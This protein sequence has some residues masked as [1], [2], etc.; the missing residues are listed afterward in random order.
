LLRPGRGPELREFGRHRAAEVA[1][2]DRHAVA[3]HHE[4][5]LTVTGLYHPHE[6]VVVLEATLNNRSRRGV[7]EGWRQRLRVRVQDVVLVLLLLASFALV[8]RDDFYRRVGDD[9][10]PVKKEDDLELVKGED[11]EFVAYIRSLAAGK[12]RAD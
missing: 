12:A 11:P 9:Y 4:K 10:R 2:A 7:V 6:L 3:A 8:D 5:V 1:P